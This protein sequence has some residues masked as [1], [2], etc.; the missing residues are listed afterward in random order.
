MWIIYAKLNTS[1][2]LFSTYLLDTSDVPGTMLSVGM[3][4]GRRQTSLCPER[5]L[6]ESSQP[7]MSQ[8]TLILSF[9][10]LINCSIV[11]EG[12]K[13]DYFSQCGKVI[14]VP[15]VQT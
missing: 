2:V 3:E 13:W 14:R 7:S 5:D 9:M 11:A 1:H 15:D 8:K 10:E 6:F 4:W 12:G